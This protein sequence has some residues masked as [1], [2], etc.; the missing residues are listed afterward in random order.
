MFGLSVSRRVALSL[1]LA[2]ASWGI[3]TAISKR[4]VIEFPPLTL[5]PIQLAVS[6]MTLVLLMRW[7][8][9]RFSA[10]SVPPGLGR[11]GL[12]NPGL[13]YSLSLLGLVQITASLSV[14]LWAVE[15]LMILLLAALFLGE[16]VGRMVVLLS[17]IAIGGMTLVVYSPGGGG[18]L[19]GVLLTLGGV[20]G[21]AAYSVMARRWLSGSGSTMQVVVVQQAYALVLAILLLVG[22]A[23]LGGRVWPTDLSVTG[24]VSVAASG[25][26][27]YGLAY[28]FYLYGLRHVPATI[29]AVSFYLI[30]VFGIAAGSVLGERFNERQWIGAAIVIMAVSLVAWRASNVGAAARVTYSS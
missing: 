29:A 4:A 28:S 5:L 9:E 21:C 12:L 14:L 11:L 18:D 17:A 1:I 22:V 30:P 2:A 13:A 19:L 8:G 25:L 23:L 3:G 16:R 27:Y 7:R 26:I 20:G 15:P 10:E 24:A 6:L